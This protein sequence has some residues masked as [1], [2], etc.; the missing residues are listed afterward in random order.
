MPESSPS[1][2]KQVGPLTLH[3]PGQ[4][5]PRKRTTGLHA[6]LAPRR[7]Q[8]SFPKTPDR[9]PRMHDPQSVRLTNKSESVQGRQNPLTHPSAKHEQGAFPR[10]SE[11]ENPRG[12]QNARVLR[13]QPAKVGSS[14]S[15]G[16]PKPNHI[17]QSPLFSFCHIY[18]WILSL[19]LREMIPEL[20]GGSL[21]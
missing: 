3:R 10:T 16:P 12:G 11:A 17:D 19:E 4:A 21:K 6:A 2:K 9:I 15:S 5:F 7:R 14:G 1:P 8:P 13:G 18:L 20:F